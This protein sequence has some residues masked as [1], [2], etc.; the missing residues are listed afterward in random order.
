MNWCYQNTVWIDMLF[1]IVG[2]HG[3]GDIRKFAYDANEPA[4]LKR[5]LMAFAVDGSCWRSYKWTGVHSY[6]LRAADL[7]SQCKN[8]YNGIPKFLK[9]ELLGL[10]LFNCESTPN[11]ICSVLKNAGPSSSYTNSLTPSPTVSTANFKQHTNLY[12]YPDSLLVLGAIRKLCQTL[13]GGGIEE[14]WQGEGGYDPKF[15]DITFQK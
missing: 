7:F 12:I 4:F 6:L 15:C 14:V 2:R 3:W 9:R 8:Q 11:P 1:Q 5:K 13:R 10:H